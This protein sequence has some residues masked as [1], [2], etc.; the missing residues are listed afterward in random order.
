MSQNSSK[1]VTDENSGSAVSYKYWWMVFVLPAWIAVCFFA[2]Q[3]FVELFMWLM[4]QINIPLEFANTTVL[5][6]VFTVI[7]YLLTILLVI[8]LPYFVKKIKT[9]RLDLGITRYPTWK[10]ILISPA[11]LIVY[12][13]LSAIL[14]YT[15]SRLGPGFNI[16]QKQ[17]VGFSDVVFQYQFILAFLSLVIIAPIAEEILFRGYL[18]GKLKKFVPVWLAILVTSL[19][20]GLFHLVNS[21]SL[22]W[23]LAIDTFALS[24]ILCLL[25]VVTGNIWS[26]ILLHM[27][28]NG[29][30]FYLYFIS[31]L[32]LVTL[33]K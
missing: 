12:L 5:E 23:N 16:D 25:R 10:D 33:G 4:V 28:K 31:P 3:I 26:S 13:L 24:I 18:F 15:L 30:A 20:F 29:I 9:T 19:V 11:G 7:V 8:G 6:T 21:G 14:L 17:D 32:L 22:A 2:A 1:S 27:L